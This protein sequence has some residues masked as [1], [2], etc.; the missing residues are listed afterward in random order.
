MHRDTLFIRTPNHRI[1][2]SGDPTHK[3]ED[4][5]TTLCNMSNTI[6]LDTARERERV[7]VV[8]NLC[9]VHELGL[10]GI[11]GAKLLAGSFAGRTTTNVDVVLW[12]F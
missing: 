9:A 11:C 5:G 1:T 4:I 10:N 12:Q 8:M 3:Y 6:I 2:D 7:T